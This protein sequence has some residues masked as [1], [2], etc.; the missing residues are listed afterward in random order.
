[1]NRNIAPELQT[2]ESISFVKP[3]IFDV[4]EHVKLF[5]MD[6]VPN[7]TGR[8]DLY[9]D[10]GTIRGKEGISSFVNGLLLS[11]NED[12][13]S[14]QVNHQID[15]YGGFYESGLSSESSV[16]SLYGLRENFPKLVHILKDAIHTMSCQ[17]KEV[18]ELVR[19]RKQKFLVNM[20]K[21]SYL[22]Q[23]TFQQKLFASH[24]DYCRVVDES[25]YEDISIQRFKKFFGQNYLH[26]LTKMSL[27]GS[28][29]QDFVDELID[30]FGTWCKDGVAEYA[31]KVQNEPGLF[32]T[33]KKDAL[34]TAIRMGKI[35]F[36]KNHPD[37]L[38]FQFLNTII[39]DYFGSRLMTNIREEKGYTYGIGSMVAEYQN[40]GYFMIATE[41]GKKHKD[42]TLKEIRFELERL[43]NELVGKEEIELIQNYLMGQLLKSADGPYSMMD[44]YLSAEIHGQDFEFY[45]RAIVSI[46]KMTPER[47]QELAKKYLNWEDFTI[48]AAG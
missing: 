17:E 40:F 6:E 29:E 45:N 21:M 46:Q 8:L 20:Q 24:P 12:F 41:V 33:E 36:N 26:G 23:R 43:Q 14:T 16:L 2:I 7:E 32:Y 48:V 5:W 4:N 28:F 39:G 34:Q 27:V 37:Y 44:L 13:S 1:M 47:I 42:D 11:G 38:D 22:A 10:A 18:T 15:L 31:E 25:Y 19:D 30:T 3:K 9:F 35:L